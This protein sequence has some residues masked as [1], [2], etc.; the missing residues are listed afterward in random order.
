MEQKHG[1]RSW[2]TLEHPEHSVLPSAVETL[3]RKASI[4]GITCGETLNV[5]AGNALF[6]AD[7]PAA[8]INLTCEILWDSVCTERGLVGWRLRR[9]IT[10]VFVEQSRACPVLKGWGESGSLLFLQPVAARHPCAKG[11][12]HPWFN[13][14]A[15]N[16]SEFSRDYCCYL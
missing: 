7:V 2:W 10:G 15:R 4:V 11:C 16:V 3:L 1:Q 13:P 9:W 14:G 6:I 5:T 8:L 12:W